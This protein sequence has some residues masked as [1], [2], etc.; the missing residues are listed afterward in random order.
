MTPRS[1]ARHSALTLLLTLCAFTLPAAARPPAPTA[2]LT[3][4]QSSLIDQSIV[5]ERKVIDL[6]RER[7]PLCETYI[8]TLRPDPV[9]R[10]VPTSDQHFLGRINVG[11][12]IGD[13]PYQNGPRFGIKPS[14]LA[15]F[16]PSE[17]YFGGVATALHLEF[18]E[19]GFVQMLLMDS[20]SYDRQH[21]NFT[22]VRQDFLGTVQT[23]VFDVTPTTR[24]A[25]GRF[26]GRIWIETTGGSVVRF[27]GDFAGGEKD[28]AEYYHF[29]SWRTNAQPDMWLPTSFYVEQ[30]DPKSPT[31]TLKFKAV[32]NVWGY[33]RARAA[34]DEANTELTV[35]GAQDVS[36]DAPDVSPLGEQHALVHQAETNLVDRLFQAGLL[37]A[38]SDFDHTLEAL[39]NNILAYNQ[40]PI[41]SPI[42]VRTLLT[43]PLESFTIGNTIVLS[44][45]LIDTT[46]IPT[47]DGATQRNNLNALLAF[48]LA[49]I[50]AGDRLDTQFSFADTL[51]FP[52]RITFKRIPMHHS[53]AQNEEAAKR[54]ITLLNVPQ[55]AGSQ[56]DFGLYLAQ[57]QARAG[58]LH[59]L[60]APL[61]GDGLVKSDSD[62]S[63]W[64][65]ALI[66]RAPHVD[67]ASLTQQ[68]ARP[69]ASFLTFNPWTDQVV[70]LHN[71]AEPILSP[72]DKM[73]FEVQPI[74]IKLAPYAPPAS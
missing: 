18:S 64:L 20:N 38:P 41:S 27:N 14:F 23:A 46:A 24:N 22:F 8:Q 50:I 3:L 73:P 47:P 5:R 66:A 40:I 62:D 55:L 4:A 16:K 29:D 30:H 36:N 9:Y 7:N 71:D 54:A 26:L 33:A 25:R 31:S 44:K 49:H 72:S 12:I 19:Q 39:A 74:F 56:Q 10:E 58:A 2:P 28:F 42:K 13:T 65:A 6:L 32:S 51:L 67:P 53:P 48:Q 17:P 60:T 34:D 52:D 63:F 69:L 68:A 1:C 37:D 57:L 15:R 11:K 35:V 45:S 21:Y 61:I 70:T 59:A 43:E